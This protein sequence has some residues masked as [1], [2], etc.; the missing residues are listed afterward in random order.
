MSAVLVCSDALQCTPSCPCPNLSKVCS[1]HLCLVCFGDWVLLAGGLD[2]SSSLRVM[3]K[4]RV[5]GGRKLES[6]GEPWSPEVVV[7]EALAPAPTASLCAVN[8]LFEGCI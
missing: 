3:R 7:G 8:L 5:R 6:S 2:N 4:F 1:P